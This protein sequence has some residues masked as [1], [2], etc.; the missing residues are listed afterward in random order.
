MNCEEYL[1]RDPSLVPI[2]R[3]EEAVWINSRLLPYDMTKGISEL[4]VS[5]ADIADAAARLARFAAF[6]RRAFPETEETQGIIES[7][8]RPVPAMQQA[9]AETYGAKIPGKLYLK[10]D[11]HLAVAGS[12]K[13]RGGIYEVLK[14]AE[15][16]AIDAG[17]I[18][19][20][21][22]YGKF[23]EMKAFFSKYMVQVGSTGNLA[24]S[25]GIVSAALG[26]RV[27]VHMSADAKQWKKDLLRAKGVEVIEYDDNFARAVLEGRRASEADPMSY[28]V[29]DERSRDLFMGYTVAGAR[30]QKQLE[31]MNIPVDADHPL[32]VY[33]PAGIGGSP[34]GVSYGLRRIYGD[35]V[36][37]FF[38]EPATC[39]SVLL[40][41]AT[42][43]FE[44]VSVHDFGISGRTEADGLAVPCPSGFVTR[45]M[46]N[47]A[48]GIFTAIDAKLYDYL[49]LL[50]ESEG[51]R[52][53]PSSCAAFVG[54]LN[55][56]R[57]PAAQAYCA[58]HGLTPQRLAASTQIAWATGGGFV[59]DEMW[60]AYLATYQ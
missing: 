22:D 26:F 48:A 40:G 30:L 47:Q 21:D 27:R 49:R 57:L 11:S 44:G 4:V 29:D 39:P 56:L 37:A 35:D 13:A 24:L 1:A 16:L 51:I 9:L 2:A 28:F 18:T 34:G 12:I 46:T 6:F 45:L 8:L 15:T 43:A 38:V 3:Q 19:P 32:I 58:A 59:P 50:D 10:M 60:T 33:I 55:L 5:D 53:E 31:E 23:A 42:Q 25:I 52:I 17:L 7:P 36:H 14:H 41:M 20:D 54:P